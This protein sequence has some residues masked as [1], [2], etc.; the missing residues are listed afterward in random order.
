MRAL[1]L[2][3]IQNDFLPGGALAVPD[4]DAVIEPANALLRRFP[5]T[6]A[7]LDWHP[8]GH[9]SFASAHPGLA[10]FSRTVLGGLP[11]TLWPD[12]CVQHSPGAALAA[13]LDQA[14]IQQRFH[15]GTLPDVD[16]YSGFFDNAQLGDTG[17]AGWLRAREV[18]ELFLAGLATDYCV[19]A[20]ALDAVR[21]GF[22]TNLVLEACRGVGLSPDDCPNAV[23]A[24]RSAGVRV[25]ERV[26]DVP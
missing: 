3:D 25:L 21:L 26:S 15:K 20:T 10:V 22:R 18:T 14:R 12:H 23:S 6:A 2:V 7:T 17:L 1:I 24:M 8:P 11:Q 4:G 16:S 9:G 5:I 13:R 19:K